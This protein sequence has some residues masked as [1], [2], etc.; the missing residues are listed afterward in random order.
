MPHVHIQ[1]P[2][3]PQ[4]TNIR[5]QRRGLA[6]KKK[7]WTAKGFDWSACQH[8]TQCFFSAP[9][10]SS[11]SLSLSRKLSWLFF[12]H[13]LVRHKRHPYFLPILT[14]WFKAT[15]ILSLCLCVCVLCFFFSE[16]LE[17]WL[18]SWSRSHPHSSAISAALSACTC[19]RSFPADTQLTCCLLVWGFIASVWVIQLL[20]HLAVYGS[21]NPLIH[22]VWAICKHN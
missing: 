4:K 16:R 14:H 10:T 17:A 15:L 13:P 20:F 11:L 2:F 7:L 21:S 5:W 9:C 22:P 18:Q 3:H 6:E 12:F 19:N 8:N 1:S